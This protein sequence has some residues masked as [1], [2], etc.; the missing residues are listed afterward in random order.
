VEKVSGIGKLLTESGIDTFTGSF[1]FDVHRESIGF[2]RR[3]A[4]RLAKW[5]DFFRL[6]VKKRQ[7]FILLLLY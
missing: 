5:W 4:I 1:V 6:L 7:F 3:F 2:R